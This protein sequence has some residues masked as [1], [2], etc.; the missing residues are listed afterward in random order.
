MR[1]SLRY[2]CA[3]VLLLSAGAARAA[4]VTVDLSAT[5][6]STTLPD[7]RTVAVLG[8][9]AA[10]AT[11]VAAP[12]GPAI[13]VT[14][15]DVVTVNLVNLLAEPTALRFQGQ[16][17][18]P[19]TAGVAAGGARSY[20]F[21][22][23]A[24]GTFL[25]EA[26]LVAGAE[27]QAAR[28][29]HGALVVRPSA[30]PLQAYASAATAFVDEAV[31]VLSELD[32]A[33]N[34]SASP[35]QFDMRNFKPSYFLIN[36]KAYPDT[37]PIQT[38][39]GNRV[40]LR[41]VNAGLQQRSMTVLGAR[42]L[43]VGKDGSAL[44]YPSARAAETIAPGET[45]D[46]I[47]VVPAATP[48]GG[49]LALADGSLM[50][51][52]GSG[53]GTA[54]G[55]GGMLTFLVAGTPG[56]GGPDTIGPLTQSVSVGAIT[57]GSVT[58]TAVVSDAASGGSTIAGAEF[59]IDAGNVP[60]AMA[61]TDG[62]FDAVQEAV[63]ASVSVS[64]LSSGSHT[65]FVRGRDAAGNWGAVAS[66]VLLVDTAGPATSGLVASPATSGGTVAVA[67]SGTASDQATGGA[68]VVAAEYF[69]DAQGAV[70]TGSLVTVSPGNAPVAS[71]SATIP[72][73]TMGA[74]A[75][76]SHAV[77]V[78]AKDA[79]G[80]WGPFPAS[81]L[82]VAVDR[83]GPA[84]SGL[85]ANPA[86]TNG[87]TGV[88]ATTPAVR[89]TATAADPV[90][91]GAQSAIAGAEG[92]LDTIGASG[93]GFVFV[94]ADGQWSSASELVSGDIPLTTLNLLP[95]GNHTVYV[96][97]RD[98]AGNWG[99]M[100]T[101]TILVDKVA[102][103]IGGMALSPTTANVG[104][105]VTL[106]VSGASDP[107]TGGP[108][109]GLAGGQYWFDV[110]T[111]PVNASAFV[112]TS[113]TFA[114][115]AGGVHTVYARVRDGAGNWSPTV[116][117]TLTVIAAVADTLTVTANGTAAQA[118]NQGAP[119]LLGNDLPT[120]VAGR[121][122]RIATAPARTGGTGAGTITLSC[123][124]TLGTAG[125]SVGGSA[126]CTNGAYRLTLNGVGSNA[127]ARAASKRGTFQFTYTEALNGKTTPPATVTIT[128]N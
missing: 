54:A 90:S 44:R 43:L 128:V 98:A 95:V 123:P 11:T 111:P 92:F 102:P 45:L 5:S 108:A 109:S 18:V 107:A 9:A 120:G 10:P 21:T 121:T 46:A 53:T 60:T 124:S 12:G 57:G 87:T 31:L 119:G 47:A 61:A 74:L 89:V 34:G 17:L 84:V 127:N 51:V 6:G 78:H 117:A 106:T 63:T 23:T 75:E 16:P 94:P 67:V 64:G 76:G 103:T 73:A 68:N 83:T 58:L 2:T 71:L 37:L 40:L 56:A 72:A 39:P 77:H 49:K 24:P 112:G 126:I 82:V 48:A 13:V 42:Q 14:E 125:P 33:L 66:A 79:R 25:Y 88:N 115:P 99:A 52:N 114:A 7:G 35:A 100:G 86:A 1:T 97:A 8:Y 62:A 15:G 101:V 32:P 70:G 27:Q 19:D 65:F 113:A 105:A 122:A 69:V 30:S 4:N 116:S 28:G 85:A 41:Y 59:T 91:G 29:L 104:E 3:I 36:G 118:V 38:A 26:G 20:V 93:T 110:A 80:N 55:F 81:P 50:L 22:A 96:H